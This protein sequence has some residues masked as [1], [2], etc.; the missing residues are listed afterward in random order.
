M[1]GW[2]YE[3]VASIRIQPLRK[4]YTTAF[5]RASNSDVMRTALGI[6][7]PGGVVAADYPHVILT[8]KGGEKIDGYEVDDDSDWITVKRANDKVKV[9]KSELVQIGY[10]NPEK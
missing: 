5:N 10:P 9:R 7:K 2:V 4:A 1:P 3:A 8:S 6:G